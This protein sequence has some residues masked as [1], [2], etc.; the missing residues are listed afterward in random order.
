MWAQ[1]RR[2]LSSVIPESLVQV[3]DA[4]YLGPRDVPHIIYQCITTF[5]RFTVLA[6]RIAHMQEK[7]KHDYYDANDNIGEWQHY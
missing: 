2:R 3:Q 5:M 4:Y 7:E 1:H 6:W